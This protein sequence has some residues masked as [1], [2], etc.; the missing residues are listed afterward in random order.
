MHTEHD[1]GAEPRA[2]RRARS[3]I[4]S[5]ALQRR[6][7]DGQQDSGRAVGGERVDRSDDL[8]H[9][10]RSRSRR[11]RCRSPA[12]RRIPARARRRRDRPRPAGRCA[13]TGRDDP[14][15]GDRRPRPG[16]PTGRRRRS[17]C[18]RTVSVSRFRR[19]F[20]S[21]IRSCTGRAAYAGRARGTSCAPAAARAPPPGSRP[22]GARR[23]RPAGSARCRRG[24]G[25]T[26]HASR[27]RLDRCPAHRLH[28]VRVGDLQT[29][30]DAQD[31][32]ERPRRHLAER[33]RVRRWRRRRASTR[34]RSP[35]RSAR[36]PAATA[37]V[38]EVEVEVVGVEVDDGVTGRA[39]AGRPQRAAVVGLVAVLDP[40][41]GNS[42]PS[43]SAIA[44][45]P[46]VEPFSTTMT[47]NASPARADLRRRSSPTTRGSPP[48]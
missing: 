5:Y 6:A 19:S 28:A 2:P 10:T 32:A 24:P 48:R 17:G 25:R 20:H 16:S 44:S 29:E 13:A 1:V 9:A 27:V 3:S 37:C 4:A 8:V 21:A 36:A 12:R 34:R 33:A 22:C 7:A 40:H 26:M 39:R 46:S 42:A 18:A 45:V 35:A 31:R 38:E 11:R 43:C 15:V 23:A 41:F 47:S 30:R 14:T